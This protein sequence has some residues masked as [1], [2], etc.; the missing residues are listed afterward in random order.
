MIAPITTPERRLGPPSLD[1]TAGETI[2]GSL[3][4]ERL[5]DRLL[6]PR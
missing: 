1:A 2:L 5:R 3:D 4:A 6:A